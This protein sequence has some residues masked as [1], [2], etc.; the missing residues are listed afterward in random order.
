MRRT[1]KQ[2]EVVPTPEEARLLSLA[3]AWAIPGATATAVRTIRPAAPAQ[4]VAEAQPSPSQAQG[5]A[6]QVSLLDILGI[7]VVPGLALLFLAAAYVIDGGGSRTPMTADSA[8]AFATRATGAGRVVVP[9]V[10]DSFTLRVT[11]LPA[12]T[13]TTLGFWCFD[14][15]GVSN[16]DIRYCKAVDP[17]TAG[18]QGIVTQHP[19]QIPA[20]APPSDTYAVDL[21][22]EQE[23]SW[24]V[25][26]EPL[27]SGPSTIE[28]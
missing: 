15:V 1:K 8:G 12:A 26:T 21:Y 20:D 17:N 25:E 22:C 2:R 28:R 16:P 18:A 19:V 13:D 6:R 9:V 14:R 11:V 10:R 24:R 27:L 4:R 3:P 7:A 23:C 5:E